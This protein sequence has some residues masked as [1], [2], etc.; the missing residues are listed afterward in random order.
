MLL[1]VK[2]LCEE[3][4]FWTEDGPDMK[5][6]KIGYEV[7]KARINEQKAIINR[8]VP[9]LADV[10]FKRNDCYYSMTEDN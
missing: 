1:P 3:M 2:G 10:D 9:S 5:G 6:V 4:F 7:G 8:V